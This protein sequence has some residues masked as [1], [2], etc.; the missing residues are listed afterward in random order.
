MTEHETESP[1]T[2]EHRIAWV[3]SVFAGACL[4]GF[5]WAVM[6]RLTLFA[7]PV[8]PSPTPAWTAISVVCVVT[9]AL[10]LF[11]ALFARRRMVRSAGVAIAIAPLTGAAIIGLVGLLILLG[12]LR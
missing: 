1:V 5:L 10:G 6:V 9:I 11:T 12:G 7:A 8:R 3:P 2:P 4:G